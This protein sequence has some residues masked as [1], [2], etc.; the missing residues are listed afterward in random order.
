VTRTQ[1]GFTLVE[2][3]V[4]I[5]IAGLLVGLVYGAVRVGQRSAHALDVQAEDTEVMR[6][7][8]QFL[9]GAVTRARSVSDPRDAES[10]SG[11]HG[12][13]DRLE[14]VADMP[15]YVGLGGLMRIRLSITTTATGEQL[16]LSR[17]RFDK[18]Q[19]EVTVDAVEQAVLVD[20]LEALTLAY[21]GQNKRTEDPAW[22]PSW[23]NSDALPNLVSIAVKP[24]RGRAWP[25][26]IAQPMTGTT[27]L[28]QGDMSDD[29]E[30]SEEQDE[31]TD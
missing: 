28:S 21:F 15:A 2:M 23:D 1:R 26:L 29:M 14:F 10:G 6:I 31:V 12:S 17:E 16:V 27:P 18:S 8:W 5:S 19:P 24:T 25:V 20:E 11:F 7:G 3:L 30:L 9:H 13:P 4:A 22:H